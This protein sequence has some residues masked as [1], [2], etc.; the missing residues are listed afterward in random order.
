[1]DRES[2][3]FLSLSQ[4]HLEL[5]HAAARGKPVSSRFFAMTFNL[6]MFVRQQNPNERN[7]SVYNR[8]S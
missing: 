3:I 6:N 4:F 5:L 7:V 8:S 1:V 2:S